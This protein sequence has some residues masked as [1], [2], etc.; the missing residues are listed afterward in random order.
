MTKTANIDMK[1][2]KHDIVIL[3]HVFFK[4]VKPVLKTSLVFPWLVDL[5]LFHRSMLLLIRWLWFVVITPYSFTVL[6]FS[7]L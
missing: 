5:H 4:Q 6:L 3:L 2:T 7:L 1:F